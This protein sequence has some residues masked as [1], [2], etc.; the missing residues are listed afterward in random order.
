MRDWGGGGEEGEGTLHEKTGRG[1]RVRGEG[2]IFDF[3]GGGMG[4]EGLLSLPALP[5]DLSLTSPPDL[6]CRDVLV[7]YYGNIGTEG[8]SEEQARLGGGG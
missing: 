8:G 5:P 7:E 3:S 1:V 2:T 4:G 6:T